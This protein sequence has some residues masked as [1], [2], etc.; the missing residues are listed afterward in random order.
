[1][2][3]PLPFRSG[4]VRAIVQPVRNGANTMADTLTPVAPQRQLYVNLDLV[5]HMMQR[6]TLSG[7]SRWILFTIASH[8]NREHRQ[9]FCSIN[10]LARESGWSR[11]TVTQH[12]GQ[13]EQLGLLKCMGVHH[14]GTNIYQVQLDEVWQR[15]SASSN[16]ASIACA[17]DKPV[18]PAPAPEPAPMPTFAPVCDPDLTPAPAPALA[19]DIAPVPSPAPPPPHVE[20]MPVAEP[21]PAPAPAPAGSASSNGAIN[22]DT[23]GQL[24]AQRQRNG[25][26]ALCHH[27]IVQLG[28]EAAKAG[29][30]PLQAAQWVLA[31]PKR[32]FFR[33]EYYTPPPA[34]PEPPS[35]DAQAAA[36]VLTRLQPPPTALTAEE[37]EA[38]IRAGREANEH[39]RQYLAG[40]KISSDQSICTRDG[41]PHDTGAPSTPKSG[42]P[43]TRW[44]RQAIELFVAGQTVSHYRLHTACKVLGIQLPKLRAHTG[45]Q[46]PGAS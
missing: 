45:A 14:S 28:T 5:R 33:A 27:D 23:I 18:A 11:R 1:M 16:A 34:A 26:D 9:C 39:L 15:A 30:T 21:T 32:N 12:I 42:P 13:L 2:C 19:P 20:L 40:L 4:V 22:A 7:V 36:R 35:P 25:R 41:G 46:R 17:T 43:N 31:R 8:A 10:T 24:N 6:C 38:R 44:A 37:Q 29:L 3:L